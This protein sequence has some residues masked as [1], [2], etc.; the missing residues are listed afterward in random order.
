MDDEKKHAFVIMR[1]AMD[2]VFLSKV[3]SAKDNYSNNNWELGDLANEMYKKIKAIPLAFTKLEVATY[4][5]TAV[6]G[7]EKAPLTILKEYM[8]TAE[9]FSKNNRVEYAILPHTHFKQA[10]S[11]GTEWKNYLELSIELADARGGI[12][13]SAEKVLFTLQQGANESDSSDLPQLEYGDLVQTEPYE[14]PQGHATEGIPSAAQRL[15]Q[16]IRTKYHGQREKLIAARIA[17]L[18]DALDDESMDIH[19]LTG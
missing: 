8:P 9:F 10:K 7:G 17:Y 2:E 14:I 4:I 16:A 18:I 1:D 11:L 19:H 15:L 13:V 5:S 12:P 6:T 3:A